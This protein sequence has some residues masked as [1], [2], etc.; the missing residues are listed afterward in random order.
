MA[1]ESLNSVANELINSDKKVTLLYAFN[2]TGKTRLSM[3]FIDNVNG[4]IFDKVLYFNAFIEDLFNWDNNYGLDGENVLRI[5][6]NSK[7][8]G[9][10]K[11]SGKYNEII[12]KFQYYT[13]SKIEPNINL[14]DGTVSF[15]IPTG[16]DSSVRNIKI[17]RGEESV[18]IW[19]TFYV[20][21]EEIIG[22]Y[23]QTDDGY[24]L[25]TEIEYIFIDDPVSSLDDSHLISV[26]LDISKL[27]KSSESRN[28]RF[29]LTTHHP[30]FYN[31]L[32]NEIKTRNNN[33]PNKYILKKV[34]EYNDIK[35]ILDEQRDDS[36]FAYHLEIKKI[37]EHAIVNDEIQRYH[38][39][40]M[41]NL[42][43]KTANFLGYEKWGDCIVEDNRESYVRVIN[44]YSHSQHSADEYKR[45]QEQE[46]A[47][48]KYVFE[49]FVD[50]FKWYKGEE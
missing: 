2:G 1:F 42:L 31:V 50:N 9:N 43:E 11:D 39:T 14:D 34:G 28:L 15:D 6:I 26:A 23:N 24:E 36:P 37:I 46:K 35:Y 19:S 16:D 44:L 18:F 47:M 13:D 40:L 12:E 38:F 32:H 27:L 5:D 4:E 22:K 49:Q 29:I 3:N 7:F 21:I 25:D 48:F 8:I 45:P 20:L 10:L 30:L 41:R 17:S 33:N